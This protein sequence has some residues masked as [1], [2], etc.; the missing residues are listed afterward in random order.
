[1][2]NQNRFLSFVSAS[3]FVA[4]AASQSFDAAADFSVVANPAASWSYGTFQSLGQ[5]FVLSASNTS[6]CSAAQGWG[7]GNFLGVYK[8]QTLQTTVCSSGRYPRETVIMHPGAAGQY[9]VLRWTS[10]GS[11]PCTI[12]VSVRGADASFPTTID[13]SVLLNGVALV[14]GE[15]NAYAEG[16]T[17][18]DTVNVSAGDTVDVAIGYGQNGTYAGDSTAVDATIQLGPAG[19]A[20]RVGRGCGAGAELV[21]SVPTL[22]S[23]MSL[24]VSS[25][26]ANVICGLA[27]S[28]VPPS[29]VHLGDLCTVF[30]DHA[31]IALFPPQVTTAAGTCANSL[32]IPSST[33]LLQESFALQAILAPSSSVPGFDLSNG[34]LFT[35][36]T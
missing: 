35:L 15:V 8:N 34:V 3:L 21:T 2:I 26:P 7:P 18:V 33:S 24:D 10:P 30:V 27:I 6:L 1:M 16:L 11:G 19:S 29:S 12:S 13:A 9:A 28:N 31:N 14:A 5:P 4:S 23:L 17:F 36:G 32:Q 22:G 20:A 25:A